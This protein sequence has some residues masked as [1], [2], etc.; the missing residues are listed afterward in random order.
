M[1]G[2]SE[3]VTQITCH[4]SNCSNCNIF[5][6]FLLLLFGSKLQTSGRRYMPNCVP[7]IGIADA[8]G[9]LSEPDPSGKVISRRCIAH[10]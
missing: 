4:L 8:H 6:F 1:N 9:T 7:P 3:L 2:C 5:L 10:A